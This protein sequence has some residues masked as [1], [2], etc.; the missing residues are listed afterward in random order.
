MTTQENFTNAP[1]AALPKRAGSSIV[2]LNVGGCRFDTTRGTLQSDCGSMLGR[3]FDKD[4]PFNLALDEEGCVFIDRDGDTFRH[5]LQFLRSGRLPK[6]L[7]ARLALAAEADFFQLSMLTAAL[8]ETSLEEPAPGKIL[9]E[10]TLESLRRHPLYQYLYNAI[11]DAANDAAQLGRVGI[12]LRWD[13]TDVKVLRDRF[14][15]SSVFALLNTDLGLL[16]F[17]R[18][19]KDNTKH[20]SVFCTDE[21]MQGTYA[22]YNAQ[23]AGV[24]CWTDVRGAC[25]PLTL[26]ITPAHLVVSGW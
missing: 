10:K 16:G 3:M 6:S 25:R 17:R 26:K 12:T 15:M 23:E 2:R 9:E 22:F 19:L 8:L 24:L 11:R 14:P 18:C 5:V 13:K 7:D 21:Q 1:D 20:K 4:Q